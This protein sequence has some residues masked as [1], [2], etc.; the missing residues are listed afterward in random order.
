MWE[1]LVLFIF[2]A[3]KVLPPEGHFKIVCKNSLIQHPQ[4]VIYFYVYDHQ[5]IFFKSI[6]WKH[7]LWQPTRTF[8]SE[9]S[10]PVAITKQ[11]LPWYNFLRSGLCVSGWS[12]VQQVIELI[13]VS[14]YD[15]RV[16]AD[17]CYG[18]GSDVCFGLNA[19]F[20][21]SVIR[22][23]LS[24]SICLVNYNNKCLEW[25]ILEYIFLISQTLTDLGIYILKS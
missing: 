18:K 25:S 9:A 6:F 16:C 10:S 13:S 24:D 22:P 1:P 11:L 2:G 23:G 4:L 3:A 8:V 20:L 15:L 5:N 17:I 21:V 7:A 12:L 19:W 14:R